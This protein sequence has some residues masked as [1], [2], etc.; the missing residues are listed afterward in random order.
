VQKITLDTARAAW[1]AADTNYSIVESQNKSD[2]ETAKLVLDLSKIDLDKYV[3]G[4]YL[5]E[6]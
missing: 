4:D 5:K 3:K 2:I 1:V 6:L